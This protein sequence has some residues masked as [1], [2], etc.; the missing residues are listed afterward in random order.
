MN[1]SLYALVILLSIVSCNET[2]VNS[3]TVA[4]YNVENLFDTK[5]DKDVKD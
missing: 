5:N 4:F 3:F 1:K 2:K